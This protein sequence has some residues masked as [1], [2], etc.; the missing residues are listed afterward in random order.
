MKQSLI[1]SLTQKHSYLFL[2]LLFLAI[3]DSDVVE[4]LV[5]KQRV[6]VAAPVL[7]QCQVPFCEMDSDSP[8]FLTSVLQLFFTHG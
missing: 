3:L 7:L 2:A 6:I 1:T 8:N 4:D 5:T